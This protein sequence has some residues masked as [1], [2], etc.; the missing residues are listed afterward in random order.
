MPARALAAT[1]TPVGAVAAW[2][3]G[4]VQIA[5]G[6]GVLTGDGAARGAGF[7]LVALGGGALAWGVSSLARGYSV[8]PRVGIAGSL[9]GI[10]VA[11]VA[12]WIDPAKISAVAV[13][14]A[15]FLLVVAALA[16]G[17]RLRTRETATD[18]A[19]LRL[20]ALFA[21]AVVVA[22]IATPALGT[23]EVARH[24]PDHGNH[25]ITEP[26]HHGP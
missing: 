26:R 11:V 20:S 10:G 23:T 13:A 8:M 2:G 4:L 5:L 3:A 17:V 19:P 22:A 15:S 21:A 24:A 12:L 7:A 6:A 16:C 14:A 18:A 9:G 25:R 1:S